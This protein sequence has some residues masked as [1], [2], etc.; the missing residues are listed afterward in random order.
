MY[1]HD[2]GHGEESLKGD[3]VTGVVPRNKVVYVTVAFGE[4][5]DLLPRCLVKTVIGG[6]SNGQGGWLTSLL[7]YK[8]YY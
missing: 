5:T 6:I 3:D 8:D 7:K 1:Y 2:P 4:K